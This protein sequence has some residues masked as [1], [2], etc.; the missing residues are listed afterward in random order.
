[1][2]TLLTFVFLGM[3]IMLAIICEQAAQWVSKGVD[4]P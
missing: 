2:T 3:F 1:M 4:N